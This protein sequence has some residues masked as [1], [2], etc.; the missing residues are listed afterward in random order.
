MTMTMIATTTKTTAAIRKKYSSFSSFLL[1]LL[2]VL[3][4]CSNSNNNNNN[5][6]ST[7]IIVDAY[8]VGDVVDT[9]MHTQAFPVE[10]FMANM[11]L[12]GVPRRVKIPRVTQRFSMA[13][14]EGLHSLPYLDGQMLQTLKVT[15]IY[16][17][18]GEGRIHSVQYEAIRSQSGRALNAKTPIDVEFEWMEEKAVNLDALLS[19]MFIA[20]LVASMVFLLQLCSVGDGGR[21][22]NNDDLNEDDYGRKKKGLSS[23]SLSM[24][25]SSSHGEKY[26]NE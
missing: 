25:Y 18:S 10:L 12:F 2:P 6:N 23:T 1:F 24:G 3:W 8:R 15:F 22:G 16:S 7:T 14:E 26:S 13:F 11:P 17:R 9:A 4:G 19:V 20:T 21:N 5:N